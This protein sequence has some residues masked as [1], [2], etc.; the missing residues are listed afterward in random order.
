[1]AQN[2]NNNDYTGG[3]YNPFRDQFSTE[4]SPWNDQIPPF[5]NANI[6]HSP[7]NPFSNDNQIVSQQQHHN[8]PGLI[9][10]SDLIDLQP[11]PSPS[12]SRQYTS[13]PTAVSSAYLSNRGAKQKGKQ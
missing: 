6:T 3:K 10:T 12:T 7:Y 11:S 13:E 8:Q 5:D 1:M 9:S 2:N 4:D